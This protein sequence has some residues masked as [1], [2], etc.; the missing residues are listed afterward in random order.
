MPPGGQSPRLRARWTPVLAPREEGGVA[1]ERG[2]GTEEEEEARGRSTDTTPAA[3]STTSIATGP[4]SPPAGQAKRKRRRR[5]GGGEG[6]GRRHVTAAQRRRRRRGAK[7][8]GERGRRGGRNGRGRMWRETV[9]MGHREST[10]NKKLIPRTPK[11]NTLVSL[12]I[13]EGHWFLNNALFMFSRGALGLWWS[14][15]DGRVGWSQ[16]Q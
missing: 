12:N 5:K 10:R 6:R 8:D 14:G 15:S 3:T 13:I 16:A 9:P 11:S 7:L 1:T 4:P 2:R